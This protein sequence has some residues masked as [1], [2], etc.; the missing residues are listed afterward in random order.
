M[1]ERD[2]QIAS[3]TAQVE[4]FS[5]KLSALSELNKQLSE[6]LS[7]VKEDLATMTKYYQECQKQ[8][9]ASLG[10][11][12][13]LEGRVGELERLVEHYQQSISDK[14]REKASLVG[15][16]SHVTAERDQLDSTVQQSLSEQSSLQSELGATCAERDRLEQLIQQQS[17]ELQQTMASLSMYEQQ[18]G[19]VTQALA[20]MEALLRQAEDEKKALLGDLNTTRELCHTLD[21]SKEKQSRQLAEA[22]MERDQLGAQMTS[23]RSE[24]EVLRRQLQEANGRIRTYE[25]LL[26]QGR[27]QYVLTTPPVHPIRPSGY[28]P[29]HAFQPLANQPTESKNSQRTPPQ[30]ASTR[31]PP[32]RTDKRNAPSHQP[33]SR[34][35]QTMDLFDSEKDSMERESAKLVQELSHSSVSPAHT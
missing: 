9:Q 18:L 6:R 1:S 17:N 19:E 26:S 33:P 20:Q 2:R 34:R 12:A 7:S 4:E 16:V 27:Q 35:I 32:K 28:Q 14:E 15:S 22:G 29:G 24:I 11:R 10:Q 5:T 3:L 31:S 8:L 25:S 21:T 23:F 30:S 13:G